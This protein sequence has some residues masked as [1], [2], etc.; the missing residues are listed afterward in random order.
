MSG[1]SVGCSQPRPCS[2]VKTVRRCRNRRETDNVVL[3]DVD[4]DSFPNVII[5][6]V[7]ESLQNKLRGSSVLRNDRKGPWA[8]VICL[9]D[10]EGT[11]GNNAHPGVEVDEN[12]KNG[13]SSSKR[14]FSAPR[15]YASSSNSVADD[16]QFVRENLSPVKLSKGKRTY[17]RKGPANRYGLSADSESSSSDSDYVDC[18]LMEGPSGRLREQ[19]E[20]ASSK[21]KCDTRNGQSDTKDP[22]MV[23]SGA[24]RNGNLA[25]GHGEPKKTAESKEKEP[26]AHSIP[27]EDGDSGCSY[28][29][30][31]QAVVD[32]DDPLQ[33]V[34]KTRFPGSK[35]DP[36]CRR[37]P[38]NGVHPF[39][40]A[41]HHSG[42]F[43]EK[44][45]S[46]FHNEEE[47]VPRRADSV[48]FSDWGTRKVNHVEKVLQ[49]KKEP[50]EIQCQNPVNQDYGKCISGDKG[51]I[52]QE[53]I[54]ENTSKNTNDLINKVQLVRSHSCSVSA[55][56]E[57]MRLVS[58]SQME[59]KGDDLVH[60]MD[61]DVTLN[62]EG[63]ILSER[64]KLKETDEYKKAL[65]EEWAS[66]QRALQI[67]AEEA[68]NLRR[69][70]KR[71][72]AETLR[73]LDMERR[74]KQRVE[75]IRETQKK[76][77]ENM[78]LK[79]VIRAAVRKE[80]NQ[81]ELTCHDMA[82]LLRGLGV[83]VGVVGQSPSSNEVRLAYKRA[84]LTFHPDRASGSDIRKQVEAEEKFKLIS[85][86]K[87][88]FWPT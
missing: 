2:G 69:L 10:D 80:L 7:P 88:K 9:D 74:Q 11:D 59:D 56:E 43:F 86:M 4:S 28:S 8:T 19:W 46:S 35:A 58:N 33:S 3:I 12:V 44:G 27:K 62:L 36:P 73:L 66:R 54:T 23:F 63:C 78:N 22:E 79:E 52:S 87:D 34:L 17:S 82:S 53:T 6:D 50:H 32:D 76:D 40:N 20:K 18:E 29:N 61:C 39:D 81:L 15:N 85:R 26:P 31:K 30:S 75:E 84:L 25:N 68:Q 48:P 5:I 21:R 77:E 55:N 70:H 83:L 51:N 65:E 1:A 38:V 47:Q 67:Q 45:G 49:N 42:Q 71:R 64:E 72:K 41:E 60:S 14:D 24:H 13:A 57:P 37:E 16:C